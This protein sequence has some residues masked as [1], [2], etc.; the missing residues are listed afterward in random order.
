M[1]AGKKLS[2]LIP[3]KNA[4]ELCDLIKIQEENNFG[5]Y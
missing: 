5:I 2:P 3:A 1:S 4:Q